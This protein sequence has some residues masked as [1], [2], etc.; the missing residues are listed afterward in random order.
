M[1]C[2]LTVCDQINFLFF[3]IIF[4]YFLF[5]LLLLLHGD[6]RSVYFMRARQM[7]ALEVC[8]ALDGTAQHQQGLDACFVFARSDS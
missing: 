6:F 5:F 3:F 7:K 1:L 4:F 8:V 2:R